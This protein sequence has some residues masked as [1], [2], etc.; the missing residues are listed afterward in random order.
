MIC[1]PKCS[2]STRP[3]VGYTNGT[4]GKKRAKGGIPRLFFLDMCTDYIHP[5]AVPDGVSPWTE[6]ENIT[7]AMCAGILQFTGEGL[8]SAPKPTTTKKR[9][10]S[11]GPEEV[12]GGS[13]AVN[14]Q[15]YNVTVDE[16]TGAPTLLEFDF[17][18]GIRDDAANLRFGWITCD[19][20]MFMFDGDFSPEVGPV[21]EDTSEGN[22][23]Q[24]VVITMS[25]Y[26]VPKPI[27]V[28]GLLQLLDEF[29]PA[30]SCYS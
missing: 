6:P 7:A 3:P 25:T 23:Y 28:E 18:D 17:W 8:G 16:V 24:D 27:Y 5:V 12:V 21:I 9:M 13:Y 11:C 30:T 2:K 1:K 15:D 19:N 22:R 29:D 10:S 20:L 26:V 14:F 4:C